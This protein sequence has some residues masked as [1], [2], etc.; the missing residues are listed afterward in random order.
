MNSVPR[1]DTRLK[2]SVVAQ[3][4]NPMASWMGTSHHLRGK[5]GS[6]SPYAPTVKAMLKRVTR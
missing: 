2:K 6:F 1:Q 5:S 3:M 4:Q